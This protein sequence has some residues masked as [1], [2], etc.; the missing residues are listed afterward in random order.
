MAAHATMTDAGQFGTGTSG[1]SP[2]DFIARG[3]KHFFAGR[4]DHGLRVAYAHLANLNDS[5]L[6]DLGYDSEKI[7]EIRKVADKGVNAF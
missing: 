7:A 6:T 1:K 5:A 3:F 4:A 2:L